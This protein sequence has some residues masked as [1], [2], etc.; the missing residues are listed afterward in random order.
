MTFH[1][2]LN[3]HT[4]GDTARIKPWIIIIIIIWQWENQTQIWQWENGTNGRSKVTNM[5]YT[6]VKAKI[7]I[8]CKFKKIF[9]KLSIKKKKTYTENWQWEQSWKLD[10]NHESL[11]CHSLITADMLPKPHAHMCHH[12]ITKV[13]SYERFMLHGRATSLPHARRHTSHR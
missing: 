9:K 6:P 10:Y 7:S 12:R 1:R 4:W 5:P 11:R 2:A 8:Y 3:P 13:T